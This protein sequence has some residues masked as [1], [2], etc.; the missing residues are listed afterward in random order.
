MYCLF[1][2]VDENLNV[3]CNIYTTQLP[4]NDFPL[5]VGSMTCDNI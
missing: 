1:L 4:V 2:G 5:T 3:K